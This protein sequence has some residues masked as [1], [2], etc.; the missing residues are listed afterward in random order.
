MP[1]KIV[2]TPL[3]ILRVAALRSVAEDKT[4][5]FQPFLRFYSGLYRARGQVLLQRVSTLLEILRRYG[6]GDL[7]FAVIEWFQPFLRFYQADI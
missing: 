3:E 1:S 7:H 5:L 2:S 4:L 6:Y